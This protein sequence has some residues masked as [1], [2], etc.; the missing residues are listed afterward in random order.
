MPADQ[1]ALET[2]W[3]WEMTASRVEPARSTAH[4]TIAYTLSSLGSTTRVEAMVALTS[5]RGSFH[6]VIDLSITVNGALHAQRHWT[7]TIPRRLL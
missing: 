2:R 7:R 5:D 3:S 6:A 4:G 1:S